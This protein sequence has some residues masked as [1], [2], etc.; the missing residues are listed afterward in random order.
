VEEQAAQEY[1]L[2]LLDAME[3]R[4]RAELESSQTSSYYATS[5]S[6]WFSLGTSLVAN[7]IEN[8]QVCSQRSGSVQ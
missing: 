8:L 7:I 6:S 1:K 5:Y 4:W 2:S 3:A